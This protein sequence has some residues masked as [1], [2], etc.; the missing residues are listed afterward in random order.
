[1]P[2][3][4]FRPHEGTLDEGDVLANV[5]F[6]RWKDEQWGVKQKVR[7]VITSEGCACED[8]ERALKAGKPQKANKIW[9]HVA[10]L[11]EVKDQDPEQIAQ[12]K[13][14][15][16]TQWFYVEGEAGTLGPQLVDLDREQAIPASVLAGLTKITRL[17][18]WQWR[19]LLLQVIF[20]RTHMTR[21]QL[22]ELF[23]PEPDA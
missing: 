14:G 19:K 3:A 11:V 17:A 1:M 21:K 15:D 20:N 7:G 9:L 23:A 5:P 10:P 16:F 4:P 6:G 12:I 13:N 8:Y 2:D 18:E 22:H